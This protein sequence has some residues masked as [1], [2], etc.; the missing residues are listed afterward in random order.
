MSVFSDDAFLCDKQA[1]ELPPIA[2]PA[3]VEPDE[4]TLAEF[5]NPAQ[6]R[7]GIYANVLDAAQKL[8]PLSNNRYSL[9]LADVHYADP[10][11]RT[12]A[13]EKK[14]VL[15]NGTLDRRLRGTWRLI[16][17]ADNQVVEQ[18]KMTIARVPH[19]TQRGT[20]IF[21]GNEYT[22]TS[23]LRLRPGI[24]TRVK[25]NNEIEAHV[26]VLP[27][28]GRAHRYFLDPAKGVFYARVGQAKIPMIPLLR[29]M[30]ADDKMLNEAWGPDI[31][32]ANSGA[33]KTV[34]LHKLVQRFVSRV[35]ADADDNMRREMLAKSLSDMRLDPEVTKATLGKPY[36]RLTLPAILDTTKKL[37]AISQGKQEVDDRDHLAFQTVHSPEDIFAERLAKD[38]G[39]MRRK[40]LYRATFK[41]GLSAIP[42]NALGKQLESA[43]LNSGLGQ[44]LEEVNSAEIY[45]KLWKLTRM[46][47]GGLSSMDAV[48][49]D[50]RTVQPSH[51]NFV[52][53]LRTPES[54]RSGVDVYFARASRKGP[55]GKLYS[56]F[57]DI[58]TGKQVYRSP[59]DIAN[60]T[61]AFPG[62]MNTQLP[63]VVA[64]RNGRMQWVKK[65]DVDYV[66]PHFEQAMSPLGN[67][68]PL[69]SMVKGQR[70]VMGS[71]FITQALNLV[72]PEAPWV[73]SGMPDKP[74]AS[75]EEEYARKLG[76]VFSDKAGRV[77]DATADALTVQYED[78]NKQTF[79]LYNNYPN[80]R[81]SYHH[82]FATVK[83]G[84]VFKPGD[85]LVRTNS[86][87]K[88]GA[89]ALGKNARI[90]YVPFGGLNFEDAYVVSESFAKRLDSEHMYQ[91]KFEPSDSH[92]VGKKAFVSLFATKF[93]RKQLGQ[94]DDDGIVRPGSIVSEDDPLIVAA[95]ER[96]PSY[97][98]V[99]KKGAKSFTDASVLWNHHSPGEVTDVV[100]N[101]K[102]V[103]VVVKSIASTEVGDKLCYSPDTEC[104]TATG[105]KLISSITPRD[106]CASLT[107][108]NQIEYLLPAAIQQFS[109]TGPMYSLETTQVSLCVTD[110]HSLYAQP[111]NSKHYS[112]IEARHLY[113]KRYRLKR[114]GEWIGRSPKFVTLAAVTVKAGQ[115]GRGKRVIPALKVPVKTYAAV[116]GAFLSEGNTFNSGRH[117]CGFDITQIKQP[118]RKHLLCA[119]R[120]MGV[121][122][123][124][125]SRKT[126]IRV[127]S[128]QW[129]QHLRQFGKC[130]QKFIPLS[131]FNWDRATLQVLYD[132]L[133]WGDGSC[134]GTSHAY[135]TTSRRLADDVQRLALHLG[136][137]ANIDFQPSRI[138]VIKGRRYRFRKR[139]WVSIYRSKNQ[140]EINHGHCSK[141]LGQ[142]EQWV[143]FNGQVYC[144]SLPKNHVLYVRRNGKPV[145]CGNSG[146]YGDK[147]I[148][149]GI[150]PDEKMPHDSQGR[151]LEVL[152]NPLG[153][154]TRGNPAQVVEAALGKIAA[155]TGKPYK[156]IDFE[157]DQDMVKYAMD[158]LAKHGMKDTEDIIDPETGRKIKD[159][160]VGN[161]F[162]MKLA[163][164]AESKSQG[165]GTGGYTSE[166]SPSKGGETGSKRISLMDTSA[167]LS[168]GSVG[169]LQDAM[170]I[171]GQRNEDFWLKLMQGHTP[172]AT[173]V[174]MVWQKF[175]SELKG[176]GIN[177]VPTGSKLQLMALTDKDV[178]VMA[179]TRELKTAKTMQLDREGALKPV[180][181]GLF[182]PSLTGGTDG[183]RWSFIRLPE[184]MP[185]PVMEEPIRR[186]LGLTEQKFLDVL[187]GKDSLP[188]GKGPKAIQTA[189]QKL[190]LDH[191]IELARAQ[192]HGSKKTARDTAIRK[193]GYL[194]SAKELGIHPGDWMISK[195]P[196][197]PPMFRPISV[198]QDSN[199]PLVSDVNYLYKDAFDA[200][201]N[202]KELQGKV[203]DVGD[204]RLAVY[205]TFKAITGLGDPVH[206]KLQ[207]KR[208]KGILSRVFGSSPKFG[209]YDDDTEILTKDGWVKFPELTDDTQVG[210]LNPDTGAF[211]WQMTKGV[212]H[213]DYDGELFWFGTSRGLD[214]VVTPNHRNW[215]RYRRG[216]VDSADDMEAGWQIER[217]Y[218]TAANGNRKWFRTAASTWRGHRRRPSFLSKSCR[219][220]DF[221]AFVGW[222]AAEGWLGDRKR[223][224]IQLCQAVK[225]EVK[226]K[227]IARLVQSL[228][229]KFS[230]G[231][232]FRA[233]SK[234]KTWVWQWSIRS[235]DLAK[236]LTTNVRT[237]SKTKKLSAKIR[238]W[239]APFLKAFFLAYLDGDG[240]RRYS[241]RQNGGG[242]THKNCGQLLSR[243]QNA[244]TISEALAG[245]IQEIA[246][247]LGVTARLRWMPARDEVC[248]PLCRINLS[249]S[250]FVVAEGKKSHKVVNYVGQVHCVSVPNGIV[251]VRRNGKPFFSGNTVQRRLISTTVDLVGRAV[252]SPN[253]DL[254]MDQVA[255]PEDRAWDIYKN[256]IVRRLHRKGLNIVEA[257]RQAKERTP[258]A[259]KEMLAEMANR[260]VIINRAPVLHRFGIMAFWPQLTKGKT[261]QI[262]PLIVKGFNADFDGDA[263]Q[264]HVP[265]SEEAKRDAVERMLPSRN[266]LSPA[267][268]KT[269]VH[270]PTTEFLGGLYAGTSRAKG[271]S[272]VHYMRSQQDAIAAY[273]RGDLPANAV[274]EI[275][276]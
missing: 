119:L 220:Q 207:Q 11:E 174:P 36:D 266:L 104:L 77:L 96:T 1:D 150:I 144:V 268:F 103:T 123:S 252:I 258:T 80:N 189:L 16:N 92:K 247:K 275:D 225:H 109:Y 88:T 50:A 127:Y 238:D 27:G 95:Q 5:G 111:R 151:P 7:R 83:P 160:L 124:E 38:Y 273:L 240:T 115:S 148:I 61:I 219:L 72:D 22:L 217:A 120:Q 8:K 243:H 184:V 12:P 180:P 33:D 134:T 190:N 130:W 216:D 108:D 208:V 185:S 264:F 193:L 210:T 32:A 204:E 20:F 165:R 15:T 226:C 202:L 236:W 227:E 121:K 13:E 93:D 141:Q 97:G 235:K 31:L 86:T 191:E 178:D 158:E 145:W 188:T 51:L 47:E 26:N 6:T 138:G 159:V 82:Q 263:M 234:G 183:N 42:A 161:R 153:V 237:G 248:Q 129:Y 196:V 162:I 259:K 98:R 221:A 23:Q 112:L 166:G 113:G 58:K 171:R 172:T 17:A 70:T 233:S 157:T 270:A 125:H 62:E 81:K 3:F 192:I 267:D 54:Y 230:V 49:E 194:K 274:V 85:L 239:D 59:Q 156:P 41:N 164:T 24:F 133:M 139:Y 37:L 249:D 100:R 18:R 253:P 262:S 224:C 116:L 73:Q 101:D 152:A 74:G 25:E 128:L 53:P 175:V 255:I 66:V 136:M 154:I 132:W 87:D 56:P 71:R 52:D 106:R 14:A 203:S 272:R 181:G 232:Y 170:Q 21:R 55:G 177:V 206:P 214:S 229:I 187:A 89:L 69:K 84:D 197:L 122:F 9:Q 118:G 213:W 186:I 43:L 260:P 40:L 256:F 65:S 155:I 78:G 39:G 19:M 99:H 64:M 146:R 244:H 79:P 117:G 167:L 60:S 211:E 35:P 28:E 201:D 228:G 137:S 114:D 215:I 102:G 57:V 223:D 169:V 163:H 199:L 254:D 110:N 261:M 271:K 200:V 257:A 250:K 142:K 212:F 218:M 231:K 176:A 143:H 242:V 222:W 67:L 44:N 63:R 45:D 147:G 29:A 4:T 195:I 131:V 2:P 94:L 76:T 75:Y 241:P 209:C 135:H 245:D 179:G 140:P 126:K 34:A 10:E 173:K 90:A 251:Y 48:P 276:Q 182:D 205:N 46:G 68:V 91:H 246:C 30:G 198:M 149:S 265:V 105:W 107:A 269:P 168:H